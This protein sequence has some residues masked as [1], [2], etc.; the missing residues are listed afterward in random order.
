MDY[1]NHEH[2]NILHSISKFL[3]IVT[4]CPHAKIKNSTNIPILYILSII[5]YKYA[6]LI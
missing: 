4:N 1:R 5:Q 6:V 3:F 2:F